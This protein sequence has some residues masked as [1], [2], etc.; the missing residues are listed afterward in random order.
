VGLV[1]RYHYVDGF[2]GD[3]YWDVTN[4][5]VAAVMKMQAG[6]VLLLEVQT[7]DK[8]PVEV[9]EH[10]FHTIRLASAMGIAVVEPAGNGGHN[11]DLD[12][13]AEQWGPDYWASEPVRAPGALTPG[14]PGYLDSGAIVVAGSRSSPYALS[15]S[16]VYRRWIGSY[17]ASN[18]GKRVNC[19]AWGEGVCTTGGSEIIGENS[20]PV[21]DPWSCNRR[22]TRTFG[23]TSSASG[24]IA[25]VAVLVQE[26]YRNA[27][28][29]AL[30]PAVLRMIL[31]DPANGTD[32]EA[33]EKAVE[34]IGVMPDL[35]RIA[36]RLGLLPDI[37]IRD[38][39]GDIGE[40]PNALVYQSPDIFV[41]N[42][43]NIN[44]QAQYGE[45]SGTENQMIPNVAVAGNAKY[46]IYVR[47]RNRGG[48]VAPG[49]I[50]HVYWSDA[51]SLV[52]PV[53]WH[54][55]GDSAAFAVPAD[56]K[57]YVVGPIEWNTAGGNLPATGHGCF[58]AVIHA[59]SDPAPP[60]LPAVSAAGPVTIGWTEFLTYVGANNNVAWRNFTVADVAEAEGAGFW[61][62]I[63]G[64]MDRGL[65][66]DLVIEQR[67]PGGL[68]LWLDM[69]RSLVS[70]L[71]RCPERDFAR[72]EAPKP[73]LLSVS[74]R[75]Q[76]ARFGGV[77]L[78]RRARYR[79]RLRLERRD[80]VPHDSGIV[81]V[82]QLFRGMEV[83]RLTWSFSSEDH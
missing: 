67:L 44:A 66:F 9:V 31:S 45:G 70:L 24:I 74:P 30:S 11:L 75:L 25:G 46:H 6:Y 59:P 23:G 43:V 80:R 77:Y 4:A 47:M 32:Q 17:D 1:S 64:A 49:A 76:T 3:D 8:F 40:I 48:A 62:V 21:G 51:S 52:A 18:Y 60:L 38:R 79:C 20:D 33:S 12:L 78:G 68:R 82:R 57:L 34:P 15:P 7:V 22:Y 2:Y 13:W 50:A 36:S 54:H 58:V 14:S 29:G 35:K 72:R 28:G 16:L 41:R 42:P 55:I 83:G 19:Y 69:P 81:S 27:V 56:G 10:C 73:D 61:F 39:I 65:L 5:V 37:Y 63:R 53:D 71:S 26:M